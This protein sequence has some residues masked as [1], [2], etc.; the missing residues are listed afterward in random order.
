MI[1][2]R[3][4]SSQ[5]RRNDIIFLHVIPREPVCGDR[6]I[7]VAQPV[8]LPAKAVQPFFSLEGPLPNDSPQGFLLAGSSE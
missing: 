7:P 8:T 2:R 5:A 1:P 3:D 6:G 4:S